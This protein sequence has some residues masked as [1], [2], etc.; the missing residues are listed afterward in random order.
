MT[1][2]TIAYITSRIDPRFAW[3]AR[4][5]ARELR[6]TPELP[7]DELQ[8]L[9]IDARLWRE[10]DARRAE[11]AE[12]VGGRFAFEHHPPKPSVWQG[13]TR[14][15]KQDWF[16]AGGARNTALALAWGT[17]VAFVDDLSA[18]S[19]GW[20]RAHLQA[21]RAGYA[22]A[23]LTPRY[24]DVQ[25]DE[26]GGVRW[27]A[28]GRPDSRTFAGET[29]AASGA[30][31]YGSNFSVPLAGALAVN[32]VDEICE[33]IGGE[34]Y[35][36]GL[37]LER[38]GIPIRISHACDTIE[39][40][41]AHHGE[42]LKLAERGEHVRAINQWWGLAHP[43]AR[44]Y[45]RAE[46]GWAGIEGQRASDAIAARLRRDQDR[47]WTLGNAF[48]LRDLRGRV[49]AGQPF[50]IPTEPARWWVDGCPLAEMSA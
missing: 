9:V 5:L 3:F 25:V 49:L 14:L 34:D 19:P 30:H 31:L 8:V 47:V 20:L 18:L 48:K 27:R 45:R 17:L 7:R 42:A 36:F 16:C 4:T 39:D 22:L 15:P 43:E 44:D 35:D 1:T 2:M 38:A 10:G 33:G 50:P 26:G 32:G 41:G 12:A 13:P 23:G 40:L 6:C 11:L 28:L 46:D 21:A 24:E 37:R 29:I